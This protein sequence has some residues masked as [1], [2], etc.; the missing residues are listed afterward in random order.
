MTTKVYKIPTVYD[1]RNKSNDLSVL[2]CFLFHIQLYNYIVIICT[3][4]HIQS[5]SGLGHLAMA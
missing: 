3:L 4:R 5:I 2:V 1:S